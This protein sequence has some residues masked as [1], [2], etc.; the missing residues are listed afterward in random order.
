M[1]A[2]RGPEV[3]NI[4]NEV[5]TNRELK[6]AVAYATAS[7]GGRFGPTEKSVTGN[8]VTLKFTRK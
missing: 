7:I 1:K 3:Y 5:D 2:E 4:S 8:P 6:L